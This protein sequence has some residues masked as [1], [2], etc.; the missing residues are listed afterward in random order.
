MHE[1]HGTMQHLLRQ[2]A[3]ECADRVAYEWKE[4]RV[5][6]AEL[7]RETNRL[8]NYLRSSG[9]ARGAI[10]A[11]ALRDPARLVESVVGVLKAGCVFVPLN[12]DEPQ[13]RLGAM[14]QEVEPDAV[15]VD[16]ET[17]KSIA[18]AAGGG[19]KS[20]GAIVLGRPAN[21][22][23]DAH[24]EELPGSPAAA[25]CESPTVDARPDDMCYVFFTSGST[26]QP[27]GVAGRSGSL[28]HFVRWEIETLGVGPGSRVSQL[29]APTFDAFLRD[30]FV[31]LCA[32][33]TICIPDSRETVLDTR[34][35]VRWIDERGL[36][37]IHC[38]PSI[39]RSL[40]A[41]PL[42]AGM[43][44]GLRHLVMA[45]EQ[46]FPSEIRRWMEV[47]GTRV[48]LVNLYGATENTMAKFCYF[49]GEADQ[50]APFIRVG[51][52][53]PG[54]AAFILDA[55]GRDC[56]P[57]VA[58]EIYINTPFLTHG[59]YGRPELTQQVFVRNPLNSDSGEI[60]YKTGDLGR[61]L[62][63]GNY[64]LLGRVDQQVKVRGFRVEPGEVEA[65]LKQH[66]SVLDAAVVLR[67]ADPDRQRLVA[68]V[69]APSRP[70]AGE[71]RRFVQEALPEYMV[72]ASVTLLDM[73]PVTPHGK[74]DRGALPDA[75]AA[76]PELDAEFVAPRSGVEEKLSEIWSRALQVDSPG[77]NDD[78]FELGGHSLTATQIIAQVRATFG[79]ELQLRALLDAPTI[80]LLTPKIEQEARTSG[81]PRRATGDGGRLEITPAPRAAAVPLSYSQQRMWLSVQ[82]HPD[83]PTWN[84]SIVLR[85]KGPLNL[86]AFTQSLEEIVRRQH[87]L[88]TV[89]ES[90]GGRPA[91]R[92]TPP[93]PVPF[94]TV[95]LAGL[96]RDVKEGE[97]LARARLAIRAPI[98]LSRPPLIRVTRIRLGADDCLMLVTL[99]HITTDEWSRNIFE[100]ELLTLYRSFAAGLPAPLP[101]LKLQYAD[102]AY[103]Q[104]RW[105]DR[106][107]LDDQRSY[108]RRQLATAPP[109]L[110]LLEGRS[111]PGARALEGA[112]YQWV[113]SP[114]ASRSVRELAGAE[115]ATFFVVLLAM[116]KVF[117]YRQTG[118][119]DLIVGTDFA[120]RSRAG[121][122]EI[123]GFFVNIVAMRT[124][125]APDL[126]FRQILARVRHTALEAHD[127]QDLPFE[128]VLK[129]LPP[130]R[131]RDPLFNVFF[132][133]EHPPKAAFV[134]AG[135]ELSKVEFDTGVALRDLA[136]YASDGAAGIV[137]TWNYKTR[138]FDRP[139]VE[140]WTDSFRTL[141][142]S[143]LAHPDL[144]V[145]ELEMLSP[146]ARAL[147]A[148][149]ESRREEKSLSRL[150]SAGRKPVAYS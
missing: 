150:R 48:Q 146:E 26:G 19:A 50:H 119:A 144:S 38:V 80:A 123:I 117:L 149:E 37:L 24:L 73:L 106:G 139:T 45:G 134:L 78:F 66:A 72:P 102:C 128:E 115:S 33:A 32:G 136:L 29:A 142:D 105:L 64:E 54:A 111:S 39:F 43:F 96:G 82:L 122:E 100:Y 71:L 44:A 87:S 62:P 131:T 17:Y 127:N 104:R 67:G 12:A 57:G 69:V 124:R 129:E 40:I 5:T 148:S 8:A 79:V 118:Q 56:P 36:T 11:I 125:L 63:D 34:Q 65:R 98:D 46:L 52:P 113:L 89:Y 91:Q 141:I 101:E 137:C 28:L 143:I 2:T 15:I 59:Y 31:P 21:F 120:N 30:V 88:R 1:Q 76:R 3:E 77:V 97:A 109:L 20:A 68:F 92:V 147:R 61:L 121:T 51:K 9:L 16:D 138:L 126:S 99:H 135:L 42:D 7:E 25:G 84:S 83:Q 93:A 47:F 18:A 49:I 10:V 13:Q 41:Q 132:L 60:V 130:E 35:L 74:V 58:G 90:P 70:S 53:M 112:L 81:E 55:E 6:Y 114:A 95:E 133:T 22:E 145:G 27:K 4:R 107:L 140:R 85:I 14:M 108:W 86:H 110:T 75:D 23:A 94:R 103:S 116:F